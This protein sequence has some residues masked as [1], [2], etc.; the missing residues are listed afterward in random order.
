[1][2]Y[3]GLG[4][5]FDYKQIKNNI[6]YSI[7]NART[8]AGYIV[9]QKYA[10]TLLNNYLYGLQQLI[11]TEDINNFAIDMYW[12]S[13][14]NTQNLF[15]AM[16]PCIGTQ[17]YG[18]S[19]IEL[20]QCDYVQCNTCIIL[21][22]F[23]LNINNSP[24]FCINYNY[25]DDKTITNI[26]NKYPKIKYLFRITEHFF[27]KLNWNNIYDIYKNIIYKNMTKQFNHPYFIFSFIDNKLVINEITSINDFDDVFCMILN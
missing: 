13:L 16:M 18:F 19:S 5:E 23:D 6:A 22:D 27:N 20:K 15:Y 4:I 24:F 2:S 25:I 3:N 11:E 26:K 17:L 9:H 21:I 8:T 14:Q 12:N 10:K 1:M 7:K